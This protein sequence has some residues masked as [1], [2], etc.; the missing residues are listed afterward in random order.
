MEAG[1][2][3]HVWTIGELLA[4]S[5]DE[6]TSF[7]STHRL[8]ATTKKKKPDWSFFQNTSVGES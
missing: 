5:P 7:Q 1:N 6:V 3:G 8:N 4:P 2:V